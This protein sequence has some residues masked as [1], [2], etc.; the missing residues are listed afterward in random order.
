[1]RLLIDERMRAVLVLAVMTYI[2]AASPSWVITALTVIDGQ[3]VVH[4][5]TFRG[6][7]AQ[8]LEQL[9]VEINGGDRIMPPL[10]APVSHGM[11]VAIERAVAATV[12]VDGE[13]ILHRAPP[14]T[15]GEFLVDAGVS[16]GPLDRVTPSVDTRQRGR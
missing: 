10:S 12:A 7:V 4:A 3:D 6:T 11:T 13:Q 5:E 14:R 1:M 15:V 2:V 16:L 8:A 9:N